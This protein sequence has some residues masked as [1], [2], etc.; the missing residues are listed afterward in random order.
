MADGLM[1]N[2]LPEISLC[3]GTVD[4]DGL[5]RNQL[6]EISLCAGRVVVLPRDAE[7][8]GPRT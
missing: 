2:Q 7:K 4:G 3:A 5:M 1:P 6:Q 8:Y